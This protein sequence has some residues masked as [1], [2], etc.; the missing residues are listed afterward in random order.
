M[1]PS[2]NEMSLDN[3]L[4]I[5]SNILEQSMT[6]PYSQYY[7]IEN[8]EIITSYLK[9]FVKNEPLDSLLISVLH[10]WIDTGNFYTLDELVNIAMDEHKCFCPQNI[11]GSAYTD[12]L[13]RQFMKFFIVEYADYPQCPDMKLSFQYY[14]QEH[15]FPLPEEMKN[16]AINIVGMAT[17]PLHFGC[18]KKQR[19]TENLEKLK[20]YKYCNI[21]S[22]IYKLNHFNK[23]IR[24][25]VLGYIHNESKYEDCCMCLNKFKKDDKCFYLKCKHIFHANESE[26]CG[27]L[28]KWL[29][30][31]DSC[32]ICRKQVKV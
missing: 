6:S 28:R 14:Q 24:N 18:E 21:E 7:T 9:S 4:N 29:E 13:C 12:E 15:K 30:T 16:Y 1:E 22:Y 5:F 8:K 2:Y 27:G 20:S 25:I 31:N 26:D 17:D 32:P 19:P 11:L 10:H 3:I 23:S